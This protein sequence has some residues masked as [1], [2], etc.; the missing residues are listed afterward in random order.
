MRRFTRFDMAFSWLS[1][2]SDLLEGLVGALVVTVA[3]VIGLGK[4]LGWW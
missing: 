4:R 3:L 1:R 2:H